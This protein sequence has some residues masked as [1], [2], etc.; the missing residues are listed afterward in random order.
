MLHF[1][2]QVCSEK[3]SFLVQ[4]STVS[5][6]LHT[7]VLG[8]IFLASSSCKVNVVKVKSESLRV[9][10]VP[11]L[12]AAKLAR[13]N[14]GAGSKTSSNTLD[15]AA[16]KRENI[17]L[18][19]ANKKVIQKE[20]VKQSVSS[21]KSRFVSKDGSKKAP[22]VK[23]S[24]VASNA[25]KNKLLQKD[26]K[27]AITYNFLPAFNEKFSTSAYIPHFVQPVLPVK[28]EEPQQSTL[29]P[30][31][32]K[33][34]QEPKQEIVEPAKNDNEEVMYVLP[35]E[36]NTLVA[37][38][39]L[40]QVLQTEWNPPPGMPANVSAQVTITVNGK[41]KITSTI[42]NKSSGILIYDTSIEHALEKMALPQSA[43]SKT[44]TI[45]FTP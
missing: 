3:K 28:K 40:Q 25:Q 29:K 2:L 9:K 17:A 19:G 24:N 5:L 43:W 22:V 32:V 13:S 8:Y 16:K 45:T 27:V 18:T 12:D 41:G 23:K 39:Q 38:E 33:P 20:V 15:P 6:F 44:L 34:V 4:L 21:A 1:Q 7:V 35:H 14:N 31:V 37:H 26:K 36:Y 10:F 42:F 11:T 30:T